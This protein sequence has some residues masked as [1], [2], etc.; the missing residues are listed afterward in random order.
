MP[1][2]S[3]ID[4]ATLTFLWG[5]LLLALWGVKTSLGFITALG[6]AWIVY[7]VISSLAPRFNQ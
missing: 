7:R 2:K 4:D 1:P 6:V 5:F 3:T